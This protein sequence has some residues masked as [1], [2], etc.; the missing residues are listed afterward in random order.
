MTEDELFGMMKI[1]KDLQAATKT[2]IDGMAAE[3]VALAKDRAAMTATLAQQAEHVKAAA[4]SVSNVATSIRQAAA[5][6]IPAIQEA[7]GAAVSASVGESLNGASDAAVGAIQKA[8]EPLLERIGKAT[9]TAHIAAG[10]LESAAKWFSWKAGGFFAA[11]MAGL[12]VAAF[13]IFT[14]LVWWQGT[15]LGDLRKE[16]A[17]LQ[18]QVADL[19]ASADLL[20]RGNYGVWV[21]QWSDGK[22]AY[23]PNGYEAVTCT[24]NVPCVKL[25]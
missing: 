2:A 3:R 25:K 8:A 21:K 20:K 19:Q 16:E 23:F 5:E 12:L 7:A 17:A 9:T 11:G 22:Y 10:N 13:L 6:A 24:N 4:G 18:A 14:A 15:K 1:T